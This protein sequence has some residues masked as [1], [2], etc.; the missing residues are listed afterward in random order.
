MLEMALDG[1]S[2]EAI[3]QSYQMLAALGG[4]TKKTGINDSDGEEDQVKIDV[5]AIDMDF[6]EEKKQPL[7]DDG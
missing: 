7:I 4:N 2:S 1:K 5:E 3:R 6:E